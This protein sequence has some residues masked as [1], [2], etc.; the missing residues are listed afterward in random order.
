MSGDLISREALLTELNDEGSPYTIGI[1][2][3]PNDTPKDI[4]DKTLKAYR[5]VLIQMV[6]DLP[7]AYDV[8]KVTEKLEALIRKNNNPI[9][10]GCEGVD[11][12][13]NDCI[14]CFILQSIEIAECG[15]KD[16]PN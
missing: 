3:D 9:R 8:E 16:E 15:G 11:C 10:T 13:S 1:T 7:I 5:T 12:L 6:N 4:V 2:I 14:N